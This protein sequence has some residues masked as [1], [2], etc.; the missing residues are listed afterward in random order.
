M[1]KLDQGFRRQTGVEHIGGAQDV[2]LDEIEGVHVG[3]GDRD[4]CGQVIDHVDPFDRFAD[5]LRVLQIPAMHFDLPDHGRRQD[6]QPPPVVLGVVPDEDADPVAVLDQPLGQMAADE[7]RR[8]C[9][10]HPAHCDARP[11]RPAWRSAL[12]CS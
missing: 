4:Q 5:R 8:P 10:Q 6:I 2:G 1:H 3:I 9:H 12:A 11:I 7:P